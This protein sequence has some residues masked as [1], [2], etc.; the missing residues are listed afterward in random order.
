MV[1]RK[2]AKKRVKNTTLDTYGSYINKTIITPTDIK[3]SFT[4]SKNLSKK[5]V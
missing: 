2:L 1:K 4:N 5:P 3:K